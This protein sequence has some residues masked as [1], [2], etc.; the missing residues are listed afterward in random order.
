MADG[1]RA[2][3]VTHPRVAWHAR[4]RMS[5]VRSRGTFDPHA[6]EEVRLFM[7]RRLALLGLVTLAL[8]VSFLIASLGLALATVGLDGALAELGTP[9]RY[10]NAAG[11]AVSLI[12]WILARTGAR[13]P[14][15]LLG[16]DL[17]GT[18]A[19][20]VP[21]ALMSVLGQP[22]M[23]GVLLCALM[24]ML[25]LTTRALLVPSDAR[26]TFVISVTAALLAFAIAVGAHL[27]GVAPAHDDGLTLF[28][29]GSNLAMW[30]AVVVAVSTVS[31]WVLFGLRQQV[32]AARQLG[33]YTLVEKVGHGGMGEVYRAQHAMLRRPTAVKLLPP[34]KA[35]A[36][37][38]ARFEREV[39]LTASLSH[40]NTITI[41]DYGHTPD[42]VFY[43]A[44]EY[45]EGGDLE[46]VVDV[47][48]PMPPERVA[49]VLAQI[50]GGL[51]EAH[52]IGLIHR[53]IKP[54]N[55]FLVGKGALGDLA[56][57]LDFGLVRELES[58]ETSGLTRTDTIMGTPLYM[59]PEAITNPATV[60]ARSDL[61]ALGAVAYF[62]LT[63][64]HVF[65][66]NTVVEICSHHLHTAPQPP[67]ERLGARLP[68]S[69][70]EIVMRCLEKAPE[71][72][73]ASAGE[74]RDLILACEDVGEW[75]EAQARAWWAEHG[76][77]V[78]ERR[79]D[80]E[81]VSATARTIAVDALRRGG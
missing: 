18:V 66:G 81:P 17:T 5:E 47:G 13:S 69:L 38:V 6:S 25:I 78:E 22:S 27:E 51:A 16:L 20:A 19:A 11:A 1:V 71:H 34:D 29:L 73:P 9:R 61:Y 67:S 65:E 63:G 32:R 42:G 57:L 7:Q 64:E 35:G 54:A 26:R 36:A 56:K 41:F 43:Y 30:L 59:P 77:A 14:T 72:R 55:V 58:A 28:D 74:L 62:L 2:L 40:P 46:T 79:H 75:T 53:D 44:M 10:L 4:A 68:E 37:A 60:D 49:H 70:E 48:G 24:M 15:Q 12:V 23:G 50:A 8:S 21:Y 3:A 33:Q 80:V 52:E 39:Q 45:L 76:A 31:S